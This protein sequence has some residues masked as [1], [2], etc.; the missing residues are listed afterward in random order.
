MHVSTAK[1][2]VAAL[3]V[4]GASAGLIFAAGAPASANS[5][6][7]TTTTYQQSCLGKLTTFPYTEQA[8]VV[9][10]SLKADHLTLAAAPG[11]NTW[12]I[13]PG[14]ATTPPATTYFGYTFSGIEQVRVV[15]RYDPATFKAGS[16]AIVS[17]SGSTSAG[18]FTLSDTGSQLVLTGSGSIGTSTSYQV[19]AVSF[20]TKSPNLDVKL[21]T[22][23]AAGTYGNFA[24]NGFR[25]QSKAT[26]PLGGTVSVPTSCIP[27]D[28][29]TSALNAGA[30]QLHP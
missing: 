27:A 3:A 22:Q 13:Q 30:G 14:V 21:D 5:V 17:G 10:A 4:A 28:S 11:D 6:G 29:P 7:A 19:P 18:S 23:G 12:K 26:G 9:T 16:A 1:R 2:T 8:Q 15:Y 24:N 25:F 20:T